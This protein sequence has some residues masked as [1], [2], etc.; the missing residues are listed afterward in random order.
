MGASVNEPSALSAWRQAQVIGWRCPLTS[1]SALSR[2]PFQSA[3]RKG[4][5]GLA[6][7]PSHR[8]PRVHTSADVNLAV[9]AENRE[10]KGS[11]NAG[12]AVVHEANQRPGCSSF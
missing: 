4:K 11:R 6:D 1:S 5:H 3:P 12:D 7:A 9:L 2:S 8:V 10:A